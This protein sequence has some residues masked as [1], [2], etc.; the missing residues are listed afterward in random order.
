MLFDSRQPV[1]SLLTLLSQWFSVFLRSTC[2]LSVLLPYLA[3]RD[4]YLALYYAFSNIATLRV[5]GVSSRPRA[6]PLYV[7]IT[8]SGGPFLAT[9]AA[10]RENRHY[11]PNAP[12]HTMRRAIKRA[13]FQVELLPLHSPLLGQSQLLSFPPLS[14][15]LNFSG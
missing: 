13:A 8:L 12:N 7:A 2:L 3:L 5:L 11:N 1:S 10:P 15:M 4:L 9:C 14:D 6:Q